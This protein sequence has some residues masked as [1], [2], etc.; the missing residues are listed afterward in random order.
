[1]VVILYRSAVTYA[2]SVGVYGLYVTVASGYHIQRAVWLGKF[3]AQD[4]DTVLA[5][6]G[7]VLSQMTGEANIAEHLTLLAGVGSVYVCTPQQTAAMEEKRCLSYACC[8]F[9][10]SKTSNF[11]W[12]I[13]L[14]KCEDYVL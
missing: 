14:L 2:C 4:E 3:L 12:L 10:N 8:F 9:L 13:N 7:S 6:Q 5:R 1:M 11:D